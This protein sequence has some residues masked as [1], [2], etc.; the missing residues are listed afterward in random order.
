M[1]RRKSIPLQTN[2]SLTIKEIIVDSEIEFIGI[3]CSSLTKLDC[4]STFEF[5]SQNKGLIGGG[6]DDTEELIE[7]YKKDL[8]QATILTKSEYL[9]NVKL[10]NLTNC[11]L[12]VYHQ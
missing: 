11:L 8:P 4:V 1:D 12:N 3:L 10:P 9:K 7:A 5:F 2:K 6:D